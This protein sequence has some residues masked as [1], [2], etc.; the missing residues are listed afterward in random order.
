MH[1]F[2][3]AVESLRHR[4]VAT[5]GDNDDG[6]S[7]GAGRSDSSG[8]VSGHGNSDDDDGGPAPPFSTPEYWANE[9]YTGPEAE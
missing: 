7:N 5:D 3:K 4:W 1:N 9:E 6:N 2:F 8:G